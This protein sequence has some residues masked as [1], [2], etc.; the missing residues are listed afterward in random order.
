MCIL[1]SFSS[2][3]YITYLTGRWKYNCIV[4]LYVYCMYAARRLIRFLPS[5]LCVVVVVLIFVLNNY[6]IT[7]SSLCDFIFCSTIISSFGCR[8]SFS[9]DK[10]H[11]IS[12]FAFVNV[13]CFHIFGYGSIVNLF[14]ISF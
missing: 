12:P 6:H 13:A 14:P 10:I 3:V 4:K 1:F 8:I 2:F 11:P 5:I 9:N 7:A